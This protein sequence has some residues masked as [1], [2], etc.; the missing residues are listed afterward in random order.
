[1]KENGIWKLKRLRWFQT[2]VVPYEGGWAKHDDVNG[3]R[4]V[5]SL[6]PDAPPTTEY[7]PWPGAFIPPF[8][9]RSA[10]TDLRST[11]QG[12]LAT[13]ASAGASAQSLARRAAEL[14]QDVQLLQDQNELE[15]LQ[16][17]YG[18]YLDK[19]MW[20][21]VADLFADDGVVEIAGRGQF[22]GKRRVLEY[23]QGIGAP[24]I[25]PG[26]L[27]DNMQLQPIVHVAPDGETAKG[28]WRLF[29]QLA[30]HEQF[31]EWGLGIYENDYV[32]QGGVWRI[33]KLHLYP[34]MYTPYEEG[35]G[36]TI[37]NYS[38]FEPMLA[39]DRPSSLPASQSGFVAPYHYE[40]PVTGRPVF[41]PRAANLSKSD[42]ERA[43]L[44]QTLNSVERQLGSIEDFTQVE[45]V[46]HI[47]GYYLATLEWDALTELFAEDGTIEIAQRGVYV[48]KAAVRRNLNLYG[49]QGL[50]QG[51]LH[52]HMQFQPVIHVAA[53]GKTAKL[54]SRAFSMLGAA[55]KNGSWMGGVYENEFVK[56]DGVWKFKKDQVMNNYFAP[57]ERGWKDLPQ[58]AAPGITQSNPPDRPPS[59]HFDMYP[60]NFLP[61]YH[62]NHPVTGQPVK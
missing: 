51:N 19:G 16:R 31:H 34:T 32:K 37:N 9:F 50:D 23:F 56:E 35:W 2:L 52:N 7:R 59:F 54:R 62:Y 43:S 18:Y 38:R 29:A 14:A 25:S 61:P 40:N 53:D 4:Y 11:P 45:N 47:Y 1:V 60:Q 21:A 3:G 57:Y 33:R 12:A 27:F 28:R 13:S 41:Q 22:A 49:Q 58:R 36:K 46:Q 15:N 5:S 17:I 42:A 48:G 10:P 55:G 30:Q 39:P 44:E 26:R 8:H 24:G 20:T 6:T